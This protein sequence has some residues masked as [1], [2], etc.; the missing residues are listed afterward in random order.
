M[1]SVPKRFKTSP[2]FTLWGLSVVVGL[3]DAGLAMTE[4]VS[5]DWMWHL[6][7]DNRLRVL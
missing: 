1:R 5:V 7:R 2:P 3:K 4:P 6:S